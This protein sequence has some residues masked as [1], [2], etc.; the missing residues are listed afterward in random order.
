MYACGVFPSLAP[1]PVVRTGSSLAGQ[2]VKPAI[3]RERNFG[4]AGLLPFATN[5]AIFREASIRVFSNPNG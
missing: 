1:L 4:D 5:K 3:G 2:G